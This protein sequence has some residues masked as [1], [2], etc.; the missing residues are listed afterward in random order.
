MSGLTMAQVALLTYLADEPGLAACERVCHP[1]T[2][3]ALERRKL[4]TIED[5][6]GAFR[7]W[8]DCRITEAGRAALSQSQ[9]QADG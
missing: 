6:D 2:A 4:L 1:N 9:G 7:P 8:F 5:G 3:A